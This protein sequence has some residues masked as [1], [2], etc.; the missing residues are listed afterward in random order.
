MFSRFVR[1][2][3][4]VPTARDA[5]VG[6]ARERVGASPRSVATDV[7]RDATRPHPMRVQE[8]SRSVRTLAVRRALVPAAVEAADHRASAVGRVH[9]RRADDRRWLAPR[10][11]RSEQ[12]NGEQRSEPAHEG[13]ESTSLERSRGADCGARGAPGVGLPV[14][15]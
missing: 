14:I 8:A 4:R 12:G 11:V 9:A 2:V 6:H 1:T 15:W 5:T 7:L 13:D 10:E 3:G